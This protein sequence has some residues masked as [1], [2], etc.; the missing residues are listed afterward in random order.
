MGAYGATPVQTRSSGNCVVWRAQT[1][2]TKLYAK[3]PAIYTTD[4]SIAI[5]GTQTVVDNA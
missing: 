4:L 2:W 1:V 3:P 5:G